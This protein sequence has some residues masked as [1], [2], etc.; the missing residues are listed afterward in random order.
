MPHFHVRTKPIKTSLK[1]GKRTN[2]FNS[3]VKL[4]P[5]KTVNCLAKKNKRFFEQKK[6][7]SHYPTLVKPL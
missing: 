4:S 1:N 3:T 7:E 2:Y 6:A 5:I